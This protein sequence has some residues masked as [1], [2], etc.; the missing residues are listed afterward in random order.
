MVKKHMHLW[1]EIVTHRGWGFVQYTA[2]REG[3]IEKTGYKCALSGERYLR[4]SSHE[5]R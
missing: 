1:R 2:D 5:N 3:D 4:D